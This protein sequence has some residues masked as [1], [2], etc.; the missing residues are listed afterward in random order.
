MKKLFNSINDY[1][2]KNILTTSI[3][4]TA[5]YIL[6][7]FTTTAV[8]FETIDDFWMMHFASGA[9]GD[10]SPNLVNI[11]RH[12]GYIIAWCY[13]L[14]PNI[15]AYTILMFM[16][17]FASMTIFSF[18]T[19]RESGSIPLA[20]FAT[21]LTGTILPEKLNFTV[22]AF[23][24]MTAGIMLWVENSQ[25]HSTYTSYTAATMLIFGSMY[26]RE[27]FYATLLIVVLLLIADIVTKREHK[28]YLGDRKKLLP[29][30]I[31]LF[32]SLLLWGLNDLYFATNDLY[33]NM[34]NLQSR[35]AV[36]DYNRV[37]YEINPEVYRDAGWSKNDYI[38]F[39]SYQYDSQIFNAQ[40]F[41]NL[42][43]AKLKYR[44]TA[45]K[46]SIDK[47]KPFHRYDT[48]LIASLFLLIFTAVAV[49][50]TLWYNI[51]IAI[52][53]IL[54]ISYPI[55]TE[56]LCDRVILPQ[57]FLIF[58][59]IGI[60]AFIQGRNLKDGKLN[61]PN[62]V[63]ITFITI[64]I[65]GLVPIY[66]SNSHRFAPNSIKSYSQYNVVADYLNDHSSNL[67]ILDTCS[68]RY[69]GYSIFKN[70]KFG[71]FSN[72]VPSGEWFC[73]FGSNLKIKRK[74]GIDNLFV[75]MTTRD[76]VLYIIATDAKNYRVQFSDT[77]TKVAAMKN[78]L[79][80]HYNLN[81]AYEVVDSFGT[82][83]ETKQPL[84]RVY[85]F[86]KQNSTDG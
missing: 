17:L 29:I 13:H 70:L 32:L 71:T 54:M 49:P 60:V 10:Y 66:I 9:F 28:L 81:I 41:Q 64:L 44:H 5:L 56:R 47:L 73:G 30:I 86:K 20:I 37:Y 58:L 26:R 45:G 62:W 48:Y 85:R 38:M 83:P 18:T 78:F 27:V 69:M 51:V 1:L 59:M 77:E 31:A 21:F 33:S 7:L 75:N 43:D 16:L 79:Q 65:L 22:I 39:Y 4:I 82:D 11:N 40:K 3:I 74:F 50:G 68:T 6:L 42:L 36:T 12:L 25:K 63:K 55:L 72:M 52:Y 35:T 53:S 24:A 34:K 23:Y 67:Y 76:D 57:F 8:Q 80:E 61:L 2:H 84:Y 15:P 14:L 19:L 46:S